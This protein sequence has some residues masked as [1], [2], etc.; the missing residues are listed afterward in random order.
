MELA[1][2][3]VQAMPSADKVVFMNTGTPLRLGSRHRHLRHP[4]LGRGVKRLWELGDRL[5][6]GLEKVISDG[7]V[8]ANVTGIGSGWIIN[9]AQESTSHIHRSR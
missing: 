9:L 4:C 3:I 7:G 2:R 1:E 5:R 8:E 6:I